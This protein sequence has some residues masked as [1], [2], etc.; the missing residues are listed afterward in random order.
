MEEEARSILRTALAE[1]D[2]VPHDLGV[3]ISARFQPLGGLDL[4]LPARATRREPP[5][6][7]H[8]AGKTTRK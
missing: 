7:N 4:A 1:I 2:A 5:Q 6:V 8:S 3:A